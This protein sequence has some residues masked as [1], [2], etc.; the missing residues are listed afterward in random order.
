M[1]LLKRYVRDD[2]K[3][4]NASPNS[5][6]N[7]GHGSESFEGSLTVLLFHTT[8]IVW[9]RIQGFLL[10]T[11]SCCLCINLMSFADSTLFSD[12][13]LIVICGAARPF[14]GPWMYSF[15]IVLQHSYDINI[16]P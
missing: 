9:S 8:I 15:K 12:P 5:Q 13:L 11:V 7:Y 16:L 1:E 14:A 4:R 3:Y 2:M 6:L 10:Q